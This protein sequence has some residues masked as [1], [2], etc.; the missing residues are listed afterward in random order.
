MRKSPK[1]VGRPKKYYRGVIYP[2]N[3]KEVSRE[4]QSLWRQAIDEVKGPLN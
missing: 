3:W 2:Q 1:K 4:A